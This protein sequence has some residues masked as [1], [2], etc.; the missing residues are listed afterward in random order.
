MYAA[1]NRCIECDDIITNPI[2][3]QC[4]AKKMRL[5]VSEVNPE[6]AEK[7]NG[8]DLDD[9]ETTCILCKRNMSLCAHCFSKDIYEMLVA[10]NYPATKEFLS[11]F[12][13]FL[14]RELSD[15]Y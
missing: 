11:R 7:I 10:N 1:Q 4:L 15:Y 5:V 6:M 12:D 13:F 3:P 2:C 14:R 8:I 9:G